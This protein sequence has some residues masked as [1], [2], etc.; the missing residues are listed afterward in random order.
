MVSKFLQSLVPFFCFN[1]F[2]Q[3]GCLL[4]LISIAPLADALAVSQTSSGAIE[5]VWNT[6]I[7][8]YATEYI[9][10]INSSCSYSMERLQSTSITLEDL[11]PGIE[12]MVE[13]I[14]VNVFGQGTGLTSTIS[15]ESK[16]NGESVHVCILMM[17]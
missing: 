2:S 11:N 10:T 15:I 6:T 5:V 3:V 4:F 13:I 1:Y 7:D 16:G 8:S 14:P 9:F 12:Y 17:L